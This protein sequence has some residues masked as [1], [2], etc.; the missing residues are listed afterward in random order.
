MLCRLFHCLPSQLD[1]ED[2]RTIE[3]IIIIHNEVEAQEQEKIRGM[4]A[5][6][7]MKGGQF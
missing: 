4:E 2:A 6:A 7:K 3:E 5:E 1:M